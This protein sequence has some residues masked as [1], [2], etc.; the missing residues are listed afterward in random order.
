MFGTFT[1]L[2]YI[3]VPKLQDP[4][5]QKIPEKSWSDY[6]KHNKELGRADFDS[7]LEEDYEKKKDEWLAREQKG[8]QGIIAKERYKLGAW[9]GQQKQFKDAKNRK[10]QTVLAQNLFSQFT[11]AEIADIV[12]IARMGMDYSEI[13]KLAAKRHKEEELK[14][15]KNVKKK[16]RKVRVSKRRKMQ[17]KNKRSK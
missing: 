9:L 16:V 2:G 3:V 12:E 11:S 6:R 17:T 13:E 10:Q 5:Y 15:K 4:K 8:E 14:E 7:Q 1:P